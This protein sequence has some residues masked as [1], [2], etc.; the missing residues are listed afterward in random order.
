MV[1]CRI[2]RNPSTN[3][4][5]L[6]SNYES[7]FDTWQRPWLELEELYCCCKETESSCPSSF[8]KVGPVFDLQ[9]SPLAG[10]WG[11][12]ECSGDSLEV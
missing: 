10:D 2:H 6:I 11:R 1:L 12:N 8:S 9:L 7:H 5:L 4:L 3:L